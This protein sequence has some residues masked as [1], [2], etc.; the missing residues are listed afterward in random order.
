MDQGL[1]DEIVVARAAA[2][3]GARPGVVAAARA[4]GGLTARERVAAVVDAGSWVEY[5]VL[6]EGDPDAPG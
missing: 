5:G 4:A 3:D 1:V 6:A 2:F